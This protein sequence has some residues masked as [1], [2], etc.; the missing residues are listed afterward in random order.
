MGP[1]ELPGFLLSTP[2][3]P[4]KRR[5]RQTKYKECAILRR[6]RGSTKLFLARILPWCLPG[7]ASG[8]GSFQMELCSC[9][10]R[11]DLISWSNGEVSDS[12]VHTP[13]HT[14]LL[15]REIR[16]ATHLAEEKTA[17]T[18]PCPQNINSLQTRC[19]V[20]GKAQ[21]IPLFWWSSG[22]FWFSQDRLFSRK[23]FKFSKIPDFYKHPL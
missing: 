21:K 15:H 14:E 6:G 4:M 9:T 8:A 17:G 16:R 1:S 12:P 5:V 23:T 10:K 19:I 18:C 7:R 3:W 2:G 22:G 13:C 20:K 11:L